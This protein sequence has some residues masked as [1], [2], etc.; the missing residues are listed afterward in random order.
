V[1]ERAER[2]A[3]AAH[4]DAAAGEDPRARRARAPGRLLDEPRLAHAGLAAQEHDRGVAREGSLE[5]R[6]QRCQLGLPANED[7]THESASHGAH[8]PSPQ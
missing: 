8:L 7:R 2:Q 3:L 6:R 5:R 1:G 4:L